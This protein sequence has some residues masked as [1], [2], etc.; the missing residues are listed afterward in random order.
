MD[1]LSILFLAADPTNTSRL[2]LGEEFREI[3][4]QLRLAKQRDYLKLELPQLSARPKDISGALLDKQPQIVHFSGHG[5]PEG[6]LCF[7]NEIG[8]AQF[9]QPS[10][11]AALFEQFAE[12]V[13]CVILNACY[14]E[15]QAEAI[16][17]HIDYVIGMKQT[18][19]DRAAIAFAI[20]FYQALG[21]GRSIEAAYNL[22]CAQIGLQ[23]IPEHL[24]PVLLKKE[25]VVSQMHR[26]KNDGVE[27][28]RR[29]IL[30]RIQP[31]ISTFGMCAV[32][33]VTRQRFFNHI[34][35]Y[36]LDTVGLTF[37]VTNPNALDMRLIRFFVDVVEYIDVD[38]LHVDTAPSGGGA[39]IRKFVCRIDSRPARYECELA[40][41][42]FDYIKLN[43]GEMEA[44]RINVKVPKEGVYRLMIALE[45][46][47]AGET[48][49]V[50]A[51]DDIQ[52]VGFF[53]WA[54][55][56]IYNINDP[57]RSEVAH[58]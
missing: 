10:A 25:P 23:G 37:D 29:P 22:G 11:L 2:R 47:I 32:D 55:H 24:T 56:T 4:E 26:E 28:H 31:H 49:I 27:Q 21:A 6:T 36:P 38:I 17:R 16:A 30:G 53:D 40:S 35:A 41:E 15:I 20:G 44:F 3:S 51:D 8:Q 18:I 13:E 48:Q 43:Y 12:R 14:S 5:T 39:R 54:R 7:E 19:G 58:C 42:D 45:Y 50:E 46:S 52:E 33:R 1:T 34:R 9:V 57:T